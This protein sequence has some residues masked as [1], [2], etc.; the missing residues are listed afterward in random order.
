MKTMAEFLNKWI[1]ALSSVALI[2]IGCK[3]SNPKDV[4]QMTVAELQTAAKQGNDQAM[5]R[6]GLIYDVGQGVPQDLNEAVKW[7]RKAAN[8]KNPDG[9]DYPFCRIGVRRP[10]LLVVE[11]V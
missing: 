7:Y 4:G 9:H 5:V 8:D 1:L 2:C 11:R 3:Q 6:L 10:G